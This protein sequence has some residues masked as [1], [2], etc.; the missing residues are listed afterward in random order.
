MK[1]QQREEAAFL[2]SDVEAFVFGTTKARKIGAIFCS[3]SFFFKPNPR[4]FLSKICRFL[5]FL[6]GCNQ[7]ESDVTAA[8][9]ADQRCC[10]TECDLGLSTDLHQMQPDL[11]E[12]ILQREIREQEQNLAMS[13]QTPRTVAAS[14]R[15]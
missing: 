7:E 10:H 1:Q 4:L 15:R 6:A 11:Q 8:L 12:L 5:A 3:D 9:G 14:R 13:S 2:K